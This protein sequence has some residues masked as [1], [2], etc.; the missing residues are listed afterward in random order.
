MSRADLNPVLEVLNEIIE[1]PTT[2]KNVKEKINE[3]SNILKEESGDVSMKIH[4]VLNELDDI[5]NDSNIQQFTRTQI[6]NVTSLLE[7]I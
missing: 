7:K 3:I 2:P 6:W 5:V 4:K 1:D